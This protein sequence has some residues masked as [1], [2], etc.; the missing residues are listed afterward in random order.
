MDLGFTIDLEENFLLDF[1]K[2]GSN[3]VLVSISKEIKLN[4]VDGKME[5]KI[6]CI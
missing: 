2:K 4:I 6:K 5:K 3:M 1:G